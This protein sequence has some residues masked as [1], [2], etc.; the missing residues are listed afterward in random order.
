MELKMKN[1]QIMQESDLLNQKYSLPDLT[2]EQKQELYIAYYCFV[3]HRLRKLDEMRGKLSK[4]SKSLDKM[5]DEL[6]E[7][8]LLF[9]EPDWEHKIVLSLLDDIRKSKV[10]HDET[11]D[12]P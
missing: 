2:L 8:V 12:F 3:W 9:A 11:L 1:K 7:I 6:R 5:L 4:S 10:K